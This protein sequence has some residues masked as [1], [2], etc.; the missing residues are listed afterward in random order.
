M[1]SLL[2]INTNDFHPSEIFNEITNSQCIF[3]T[4]GKIDN[5]FIKKMCDETAA[6]HNF[7]LTND[8]NIILE[9]RKQTFNKNTK[10]H[11][12]NIFAI[13]TDNEGFDLSNNVLTSIYYYNID[14]NIQNNYLVF[15]KRKYLFLHEE[16]DRHKIKHKD[17][18]T[19]DNKLH[20]PSN[21]FTLS[22]KNVR[23]DLLCM[24]IVK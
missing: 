18:V 19:F 23:R 3:G 1:Y 16:V 11:K 5:K 14:E 20:C 4:Y 12:I 17:I 21:Y 10:K 2:N 7:I 13:H 8:T 9:H 22:E 15:Y 24:F 6:A